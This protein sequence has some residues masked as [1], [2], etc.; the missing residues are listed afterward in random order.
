MIAR[1]KPTH[2][3]RPRKINRFLVLLFTDPASDFRQ[4]GK[5]RGPKT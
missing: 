5:D 1:Y 3:L 4:V 2:G